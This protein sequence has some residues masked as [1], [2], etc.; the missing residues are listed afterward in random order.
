VF[1]LN[2]MNL[3]SDEFRAD[4]TAHGWESKRAALADADKVLLSLT[5]VWLRRIPR[6]CQPKQL[7]RYYPR[8][9]NAIAESWDDQMFGD[10]LLADLMVDCRGSRAGFPARIVEELDMLRRLRLYESRTAHRT[11]S[12]HEVLSKIVRR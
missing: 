5:H 8:V 4:G 6:H 3:H 10:R 11:E 2:L 1:T 9:A 7:C 12:V